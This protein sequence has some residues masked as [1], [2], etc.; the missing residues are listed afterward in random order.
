MNIRYTFDFL[1][2]AFILLSNHSINKIIGTGR[3]SQRITQKQQLVNKN[4]QNTLIWDIEAT[5]VNS[6]QKRILPIHALHDV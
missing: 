2:I 6:E 5:F 3:V 1:N 4:L